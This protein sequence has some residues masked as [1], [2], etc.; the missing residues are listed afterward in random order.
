MTQYACFLRSINVGGKNK[1]KMAELNALLTGLGFSKPQTLLQSGNALFE[2][3]GSASAFEKK[4]SAAIEKSHGFA[5]AIMLRT[6]DELKAS[7]AANPF[8]KEAKA[9]PAHLLIMFLAG[10][11]KADAKKALTAL[12]IAPEA[13][14]LGTREVYLWYPHGIGT[15]KKLARVPLEKILGTSGTARNIRTLQALLEL[16]EA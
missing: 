11:P 8:K 9:D 16:A 13:V 3:K 5:P 7:L 15:S 6:V 1:I 12:D 2:A 10:N 14:S 4:I